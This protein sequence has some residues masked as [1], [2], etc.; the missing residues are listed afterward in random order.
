MRI[1]LDITDSEIVIGATILS[2]RIAGI[3]MVVQTQRDDA[4]WYECETCG[5]LFDD[6]EDAKKHEEQ[7]DGEEPTYIQ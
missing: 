4:T 3:G 5:L 2:P 7:C 1:A 6:Q